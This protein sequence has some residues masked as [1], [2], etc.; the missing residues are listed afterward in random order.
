MNDFIA[1][2]REDADDPQRNCDFIDDI[3]DALANAKREAEEDFESLRRLA[4]IFELG[5]PQPQ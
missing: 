4:D 2:V 5:I 3:L 1:C